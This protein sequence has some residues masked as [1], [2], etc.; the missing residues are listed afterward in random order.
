MQSYKKDQSAE[1]YSNS[2]LPSC[3][4]V[5]TGRL[6]HFWSIPYPRTDNQRKPSL[7]TYTLNVCLQCTGHKNLEINEEIVHKSS[8]CF[9]N[10]GMFQG[11]EV[12]SM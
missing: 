10:E 4:S 5:L 3:C 8:S 1:K 7:Q 2:N 9:I 11:K 12:V 6:G